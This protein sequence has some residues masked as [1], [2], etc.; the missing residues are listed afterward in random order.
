MTSVIA[1]VVVPILVIGG[2]IVGCILLAR[3]EDP[4]KDDSDEYAS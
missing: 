4:F 3:D 1:S 2:I